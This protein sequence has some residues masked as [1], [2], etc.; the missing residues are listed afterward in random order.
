MTPDETRSET[1]PQCPWCLE[2]FNAW[3][4]DDPLDSCLCPRC[5]EPIA[6]REATVWTT[7]PR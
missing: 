1:R 5:G 2:F 3:E 6:V 7:G 4:A